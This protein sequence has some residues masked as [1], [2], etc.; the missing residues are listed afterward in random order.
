[1]ATQITANRIKGLIPLLDRKKVGEPFVC[2]G[3]NFLVDTNGPLS[4]FGKTQ[5]KFRAFEDP[6]YIQSFEVAGASFIFI[7]NAVLKY[8]T[9]N[10]EFVPVLTFTPIGVIW[11]WTHA[12]VAGNHY[13]AKKGANLIEYNP[14]TDVWTEKTGGDVPTDIYA[15]TQSGGRLI[16]LSR[17]WVNCSAID[18]FDLAISS[19]TGAS[20]QQLAIIGNGEPLGLQQTHDGFIVYTEDGL[21]K[22]DLVVSLN[23]FRYYV[24]ST[25]PEHRVVNPFCITQVTNRQHIFLTANGLFTTQG[26]LPEPWQPLMS[27]YFHT[28][29]LPALDLTD[30]NVVIRLT[31]AE[32][33]SWF[34]VSIAEGGQAAL[35]TKAFVLYVPSDEWG[36]LNQV[37]AGFVNVDLTSGPAQGF[38]FAMVDSTGKLFRFSD[39]AQDAEWPLENE[40]STWQYVYKGKPVYPA[41]NELGVIR[42]PTIAHCRMIDESAMIDPG[43]Y[44]LES[45]VERAIAPV[46]QT[47]VEQDAEAGATYVFKTTAKGSSAIVQTQHALEAKTLLPLDSEITVGPFRM[48]DQK[49]VDLFSAVFNMSV[50]MLDSSIADTFEDWLLDYD[51]EVE[52]DWATASGDEDW[53]YSGGGTTDY[54]AELI[55]TI[56]AYNVYEDM[57]KLPTLISQEGRTRLYD[58]DNNGIYHLAKFT[59]DEAGES[60]HLKFLELSAINAGRF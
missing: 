27:E 34:I 48:T 3:K 14:T 10:Q 53:G 59:A 35:F 47:A 37:H 31:Y 46:D 20:A 55:S 17:Y 4:G 36:V 40:L 7:D 30:N 16:I 52:I 29:I 13:F 25:D 51:V 28:E 8:D 19:V 50:Q 58:C 18:E 41:R 6:E 22:A 9:D 5:M 32:R 33:R 21:L 42:F 38:Q 2:E 54:E 49:N 26:K 57:Q 60:F 11:P 24:L 45:L 44:N 1:M 56:D 39:T 43:V 15:V 23:P 12:A